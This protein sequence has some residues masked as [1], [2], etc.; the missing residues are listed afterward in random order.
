MNRKQL[1]IA[2]ALFLILGSFTQIAM[3]DSP[4]NPCSGKHAENPCGEKAGNPCNVKAAA[5]GNMPAVN[6]CFAKMGTVFTIADPMNRNSVTF[7]S[8]APLE[9]IVG[10]SNEISGYLVFDPENPKKGGRGEIVV[11][12]SSLRTGIPLRDEHVQGPDWLDAAAHGQISFRIDDVKGVERIKAGDGYMTYVLT[13]T[14][15]FTLHGVSQQLEAKVTLTYLEASEMTRGK[16]EGNLL[17]AR[18][19]F[20]VALADFDIRGFKGVVGSKVGESIDIDV[21]LMASDAQ[22]SAAQTQ[23]PCGEKAAKMKSGR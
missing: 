21:S 2:F 7:R 19:S 10:T 5:M 22:M 14:G 8:E 1:S 16:M 6:P 11:P 23:N 9:D 12:V 15:P 17:A 20:T 3:A 4:D 13:V 18:T